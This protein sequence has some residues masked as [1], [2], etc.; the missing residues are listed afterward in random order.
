MINQVSLF[1]AN[2]LQNIRDGKFEMKLKYI[3]RTL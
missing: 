1:G 2:L 3:L